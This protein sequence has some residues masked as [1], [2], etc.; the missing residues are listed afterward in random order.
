M[1]RQ[2]HPRWARRKGVAVRI[3]ES[4]RTAAS[5]GTTWGRGRSADDGGR[6]AAAASERPVAARIRE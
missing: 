5:L 3:I 2:S 1:A 6:T 4:A